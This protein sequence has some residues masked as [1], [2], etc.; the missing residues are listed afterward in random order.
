MYAIVLPQ[1]PAQDSPSGSAKRADG[2]RRAVVAGN[3]GAV[4]RRAG[5]V[6]LDALLPPQCLSCRTEVA[7]P[8]VLCPTCWGAIRFLGPPQCAVCGMPFELP[9]PDGAL[10]AA[11]LGSRPAFDA[12][13]A[14]FRYDEGSRGLILSFKHGDRTEAAPAFGLWLARAGGELIAR[15]DLI[16]PVPLHWTRL[17]RRRYNQSALLAQSLAKT[18]GVP[19]A[20]DLLRRRRATP[21]QGRLSRSGRRRNVQGAFEVGR[22]KRARLTGRRVLLI[23]DVLTTGA[24]VEACSATLLRAGAASVDVLTLARVVSSS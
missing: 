1:C 14:V 4:L 18:S 5:A 8:G 9:S 24:T 3:V 6:V 13:R 16:A 15:A 23:D 19:V 21:S 12:A 10:C 22:E 7:E 20:L 17:F 11:C 2:M